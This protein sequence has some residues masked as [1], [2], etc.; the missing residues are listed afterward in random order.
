MN[1]Q[2]KLPKEP[3]KKR[4]NPYTWNSRSEDLTAKCHKDLSSA[5]I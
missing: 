4:I 2:T 5:I 1:R 3:V